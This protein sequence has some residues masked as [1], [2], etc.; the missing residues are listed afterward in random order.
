MGNFDGLHVA[1]KLAPPRRWQDRLTPRSKVAFPFGPICVARRL[2]HRMPFQLTRI[3]L[4]NNGSTDVLANRLAG[5]RPLTATGQQ[6]QCA[7]EQDGDD[8]VSREMALLVIHGA[9]LW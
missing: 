5:G 9:P 4:L 7:R 8:Q 2:N 1:A 3:R 6:T